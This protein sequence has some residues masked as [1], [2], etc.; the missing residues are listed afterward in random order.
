MPLQWK[1]GV[2]PTGPPGKSQIVISFNSKSDMY[3]AESKPRNSP[4]S[5]LGS[6]ASLPPS[7]CLSE[8]FFFFFL[9]FVYLA[10]SG[11]HCGAWA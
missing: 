9:I 10:A 7:L 3:E 1:C 11:L 4:L 5:V 8:S 6:L 2:L